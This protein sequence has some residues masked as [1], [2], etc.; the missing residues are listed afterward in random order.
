MPTVTKVVALT[1]NGTID[2]VLAGSI[3]E[4]LPWPALIE[5]GIVAD[6][7]GVLASIAS[8]S[9][10]LVESGPVEI[11]SAINKFPVYP[12]NFHYIDEASFNDLLKISL[13][14]TSGAARTVPVV[15]RFTPVG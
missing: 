6:A 8:G 12:D 13:R 10:I 2:S 5:V 7:A 9:D 3:Y 14:D 1:A 15:V 4:R 11:G